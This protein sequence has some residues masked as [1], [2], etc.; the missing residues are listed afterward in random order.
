MATMTR[1]VFVE[2][3]VL[4]ARIYRRKLEDAGYKVLLAEDGLAAM[5]LIPECRPDLVVLDILLPKLSGVDVLK[6]LRQQPEF[7]FLP[8]VVFSNVF[9]NTLWEELAGWEVQE[10]LLKSSVT[11]PQLVATIQKILKQPGMQ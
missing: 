3:D 4:I 11:P 7:K 10:M 5:K 8:V 6:F 9:L 1:I 2:D